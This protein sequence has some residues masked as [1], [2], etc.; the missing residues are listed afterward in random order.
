V[1]HRQDRQVQCMLSLREC[2]CRVEILVPKL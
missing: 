2:F 1:V